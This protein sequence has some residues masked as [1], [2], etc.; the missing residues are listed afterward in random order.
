MYYSVILHGRR[1]IF[2]LQ[3]WRNLRV[4]VTLFQQG[5]AFCNS[6]S[7]A[8]ASLQ[9]GRKGKTFTV[10]YLVDSLGLPTKLAES[11][12]RK[13]IYEGKGNPDSVL[14]L[15]R[16]YG[17]GFSEGDVWDRFKKNPQFLALSE[18]NVLNSIE[19]FLGVGF[20]RDEIVLMAKRFSQCLNLSAESVKNKT[21][22]LVEKMN[23]PIQALVS[24]PAVFGYSLEKR[25]VPRCNVVKALMS[26]GLLGDKL[27]ATSRVLAITDQAFLNKFV[28]IHDDEK[29]VRELMAIF[30]RGLVS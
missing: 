27:P 3:K 22:F 14:D 25:T 5:S 12:S 17:L 21:E 23:W 19:T 10:S 29:L 4:S 26:R 2:A 16:D 11:I 6:F 9:D 8:G 24:N 20:S 18:K 15:F 28:K 1:S 13:V 30:T 7:S